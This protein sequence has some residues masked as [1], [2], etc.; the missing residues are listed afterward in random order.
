MAESGDMIKELWM[1]EKNKKKMR[2]K[3]LSFNRDL[4]IISIKGVKLGDFCSQAFAL[5]TE[6]NQTK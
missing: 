4:E 2:A 6:S 3:N 5:D 1:V